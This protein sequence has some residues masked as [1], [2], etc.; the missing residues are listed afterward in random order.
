MITCPCCNIEQPPENFHRQRS[1][2]NG[3]RVYCKACQKVRAADYRARNKHKVAEYNRRY[4]A[5]NR[6]RNL[7][8]E[9][10]ERALSDQAA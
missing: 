3:R 10:E 5:K 7:A 6:E 8:L 9:A 4:A 2:A 1:R